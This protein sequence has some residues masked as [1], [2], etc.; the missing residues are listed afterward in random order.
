MGL[1]AGQTFYGDSLVLASVAAGVAAGAELGPS[2]TDG[3]LAAG[4][5][6]YSAVTAEGGPGGLST[7]ESVP[8]G[9]AGVPFHGGP[10]TYEAG[11]T[12]SPG[13]AVGVDGGQLRAANSGDTS[14][15]VI[16]IAGYGGGSDGGNDYSSDEDVPVYLIE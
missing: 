7:N 1:N 10:V 2:A 5:D 14:P 8:S 15:N 12:I 11:E 9:T 13:D 16:G 4:S 3:E 6:G